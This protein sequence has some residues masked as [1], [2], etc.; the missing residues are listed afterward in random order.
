M[1]EDQCPV[2]E[3]RGTLPEVSWLFFQARTK[4]HI[5][6]IRVE[7][8]TPK[9]S[10]L[11]PAH[12]VAMKMGREK[13][14]LAQ[15]A[16]KL[17]MMRADLYPFAFRQI[18]HFHPGDPNSNEPQR[19]MADRCSHPTNLAILPL[20]KTEPYPAVRHIFSEPNRRVSRWN[21]GLRIQH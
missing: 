3:I 11:A 10:Q 4:T 8:A 5:L 17:Q 15:A 20:G 19:R 6:P 16:S 13:C 1:I 7:R 18:V 2:P 9:N 12:R 14:A 21:I